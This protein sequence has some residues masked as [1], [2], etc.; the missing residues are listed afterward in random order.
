MAFYFH[1]QLSYLTGSILVIATGVVVAQSASQKSIAQTS[2]TPPTSGVTSI[3]GAGASSVNVLFVGS[4]T[5]YPTATKGSWFN[6][7]GVGNPPSLNND[8]PPQPSPASIPAFPNGTYGPV[9]STVTFRYASVGSGTGITAFTSQTAPLG[10]TTINTPVSFAASDDPLSG[11]VTIAGGPNSGPAVQVPV[12]GTGIVLS[13]NA[14]GLTIP[15]G[16]L[17]LS[18]ATYLAILKGSITNWN[19]LKIRNDNGGAI[20]AVNKPLVVVRRSDDSGSTFAL[21]S[22]LRTAF[23]T[24]S[25]GWNRG[26]GKKSIAQPAS[27]IPNPLPADTVV[28]PANFQSASGG[29]GVADKIKATAGAIGY[30]DS[31]TRLAKSLPA[32]LLQNKAGLYVAPTAGSIGRAFNGVA[33]TDTDA[34]RIKIKVDDPNPSGQTASTAVYPIVTP[35]YLLFYST[36]GNSKISGGIRAYINWALAVPASNS[37]TSTDPNKIASDRGYAPLPST[38]KNSARTVVQTYVKP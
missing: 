25:T 29:G 8:V 1:R 9:N 21:S 31:A 23:G 36:Y 35:T 30:V 5:N 7:F 32:A 6:V 38:I 19:D 14:S 18:R 2:T 34:R 33:D 20:I 15:S 22:H 3:N 12:V 37:G 27:G 24:T 4:G 11:A 10:T 17:K 28:W 16:G 26:V 13:Y